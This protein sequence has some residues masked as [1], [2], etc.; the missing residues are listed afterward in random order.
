MY[1]SNSFIKFAYLIWLMQIPVYCEQVIDQSDI[2][3][4]KI[5]RITAS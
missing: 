2:F 1:I 3:V 5:K 4:G